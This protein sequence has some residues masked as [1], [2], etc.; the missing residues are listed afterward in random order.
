[1]DKQ[2]ASQGS[3]GAVSHFART[4][5]IKQQREFLPIYAARAE[6]SRLIRE[7][8]VVIIVGETGSGK[9]TQLVQYLREDGYCNNGMIG[10]TQL[11]WPKI[12]FRL[13]KVN[14]A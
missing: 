8:S 2:K 7:H 11:G 4:K 3:A 14:F 9:T 12:F 5:S 6:L 1:M 13:E 10:C